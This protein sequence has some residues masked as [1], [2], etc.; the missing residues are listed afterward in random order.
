MR[1]MP[2]APVSMNVWRFDRAIFRACRDV[3]PSPRGEFE[4]PLA[5]QYGVRVLGLRIRALPF[6]GSVLDLSSRGDIASVS[7]RLRDVPVRL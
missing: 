1:R 2:D 5:V 6:Q 4:I 7:A 3:P